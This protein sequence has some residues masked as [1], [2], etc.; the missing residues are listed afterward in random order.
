MKPK[1]IWA[2]LG[3]NNVKKT[4]EFYENLGFR[5]NGK[6]TSELISFLVGDGDF[7]IHFFKNEELKSSLE[8]EISD[9]NKGNEIMFTL[10]AE[11]KT[12]VNEWINEV[13][14]AGGKIVFD[15]RKD[16]KEMYEE[17]GFYVLVFSDPDGHKFNVFYNTNN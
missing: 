9:L 17:N 12:E 14:N 15:P 3:V 10:S 8:G 6:P 2:N 11:S 7:I 4:Q 16:K 1:K 5:I 13:E